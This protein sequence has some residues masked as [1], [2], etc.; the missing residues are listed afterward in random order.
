MSLAPKCTSAGW[1]RRYDKWSS[2]LFSKHIR[3]SRVSAPAWTNSPRATRG[4]PVP[5]SF[6]DREHMD[7]GQPIPV[8]LALEDAHR[9]PG[10]LRA[11]AA[12]CD[13]PFGD[14]VCLIARA[15][16]LQDFPGMID[17]PLNVFRPVSL[18]VLRPES[19]DYRRRSG[20]HLRRTCY[21]ASPRPGC[22]TPGATWRCSPPWR[23]GN[24]RF[25]RP[26]RQRPRCPKS[27][28]TE[29]LLRTSSIS[30]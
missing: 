14:L 2:T 4:A 7:L 17:I 8:R 23:P 25:P 16:G 11:A 28:G 12:F 9:V 22:C 26:R 3:A 13:R 1:R 18:D 30:P 19:A 29:P 10:V 15:A 20:S 6:V 21:R 24:P 5:L 27:I